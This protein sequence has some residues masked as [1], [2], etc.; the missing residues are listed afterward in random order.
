MRSAEKEY[1]EMLS[2]ILDIGTDCISMKMHGLKGIIFVEYSYCN[3]GNFNNKMYSHKV[4]YDF[5]LS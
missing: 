3:F 4:S 5:L 2:R 1:A